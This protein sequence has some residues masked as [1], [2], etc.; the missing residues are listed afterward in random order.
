V[1][2]GAGRRVTTLKSTAD[3]GSNL[4]IGLGQSNLLAV[5]NLAYH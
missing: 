3:S 5:E 2:V 1:L 4:E